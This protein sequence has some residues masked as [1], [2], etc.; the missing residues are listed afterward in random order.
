MKTQK[1][2]KIQQKIKKIKNYDGKK[3]KA[4]FF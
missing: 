4:E 3:K 2:Q 1:F